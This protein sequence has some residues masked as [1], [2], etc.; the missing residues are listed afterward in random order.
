MTPHADSIPALTR[1]IQNEKVH[2]SEVQ[3]AIPPVTAAQNV[4]GGTF[5]PKLLYNLSEREREI[6]I[7]TTLL[8]VYVRLIV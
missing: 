8:F 4:F 1:V 6:V 3:R 5:I 2:G 7:I